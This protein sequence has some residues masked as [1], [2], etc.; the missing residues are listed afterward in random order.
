M[1]NSR[2]KLQ[3]ERAGS[4]SITKTKGDGTLLGGVCCYSGS[5]PGSSMDSMAESWELCRGILGDGKH[6]CYTAGPEITLPGSEIC[7]GLALLVPLTAPGSESPASQDPM[8]LEETSIRPQLAP[9]RHC[10]LVR[11]AQ[12]PTG[13]AAGAFPP[14]ALRPSRP[15]TVRST[16]ERFSFRLLFLVLGRHLITSLVSPGF[17]LAF[18]QYLVSNFVAPLTGHRY[19]SY[20]NPTLA[21]RSLPPSILRSIL[22]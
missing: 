12:R 2:S 5:L 19:S 21:S 6:Q 20:I 14:W 10:G 4:K 3:G 1:I 18:F 16:S 9:Y 11:R 17:P 8:S 13:C 7:A 15:Q 22:D